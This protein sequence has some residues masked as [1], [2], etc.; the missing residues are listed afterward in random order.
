MAWI[1]DFSWRAEDRPPIDV[2]QEEASRSFKLAQQVTDAAR[3][4]MSPL[5]LGIPLGPENGLRYPTPDRPFRAKLERRKVRLPDRFHLPVGPVA[6]DKYRSI[7][8][9]FEPGVHKFLPL[10]IIGTDCSI[11]T[12]Y[13]ILNIC[14]RIDTII[15]ERSP[16][17]GVRCTHIAGDDLYLPKS[18]DIRNGGVTSSSVAIGDHHLWF[19]HKLRMVMISNPLAEALLTAGIIKRYDDPL[20]YMYPV[21]EI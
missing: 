8:E 4:S 21:E 1:L 9:R 16:M 10:E 14:T 7:I 20:D 17:I 11:R 18:S 13:T 5:Y 19:E 6:S 3:S 15:P 2:S 12:G